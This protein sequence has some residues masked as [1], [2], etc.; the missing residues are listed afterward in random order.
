MDSKD[1][2]RVKNEDSAAPKVFRD[3]DEA[4]S[5]RIRLLVKGVASNGYGTVKITVNIFAKCSFE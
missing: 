5:D 1:I 3:L 4:R 2:C